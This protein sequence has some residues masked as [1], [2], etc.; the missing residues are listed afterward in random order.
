MGKFFTCETQ[1]SEMGI[2]VAEPVKIT[3]APVIIILQEAFGVNQHIRSVCDR[4]AA[5]GFLA[6]APELYHRQGK[7][8]EVPYTN[9]QEMMPLLR[10]LTN[11][12]IIQDV[13]NTINFLEDLQVADTQNVST[14]GFCVGGF[15]SVLCATKLNLKKMVSFYGGGMVH[16][17][18]SFTLTPLIQDMHLI[19]SKCLFFFGEEDRSIPREDIAMIEKKLVSSK[20][21]F[22]VNIFEN[23]DHG[24]FCDERTAYNEEAASASWL[25]TLAFLKD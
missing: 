15:A 14:V 16:P 12:E 11:Q 10:K 20:V 7:H 19:K 17:R 8:L 1:Q 22:S 21:S 25:K 3:K 5:E 13:R 23:A 4:F 24:F 6:A 18:E 9:M 2:Y